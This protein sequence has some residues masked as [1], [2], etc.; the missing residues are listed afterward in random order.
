MEAAAG[1]GEGLEA[2]AEPPESP[3]AL[4]NKHMK[5]GKDYET[6]VNDFESDMYS[7]SRTGWRLAV[8]ADAGRGQGETILGMQKSKQGMERL[9]ALGR[10][11]ERMYH[12][13]VEHAERILQEKSPVGRVGTLAGS[14]GW[15]G[16]QVEGLRGPARGRYEVSS[17]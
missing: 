9:E 15:L 11:L 6:W 10:D 3:F 5:G 7:V 13:F 17:H 8:A 16:L 12:P 2:S 1:Q 14:S 4:F